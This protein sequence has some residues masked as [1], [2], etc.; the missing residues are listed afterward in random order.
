MLQDLAYLVVGAKLVR[1]QPDALAHEEGVVA[2][3]LLRHWIL[4]RSS[5][6]SMTRSIGLVQGFEEGVH[7]APGLDGQP[8]EVDGGEA[9]VPPAGDDLVGGVVNGCR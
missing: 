8:G 4:N 3:Q 9:Q 5:S 1:V 7:V 2:D 6:W